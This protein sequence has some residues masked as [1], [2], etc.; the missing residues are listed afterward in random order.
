[1]VNEGLLLMALTR[2]E[3][4]PGGLFL[5]EGQGRSVT[6]VTMMG[7]AGKPA[8]CPSP[9]RHEKHVLG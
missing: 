6:K 4:G 7:E 2:R 1:L 3:I 9:C 8:S 5:H